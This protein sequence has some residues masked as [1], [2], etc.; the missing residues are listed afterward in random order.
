MKPT[1]K[2]TISSSDSKTGLQIDSFWDGFQS[3]ISWRML[4]LMMG[5]LT[6]M[7]SWCCSTMFFLWMVGCVCVMGSLS[8][9]MDENNLQGNHG[10]PDLCRCAAYCWNS[11]C[12][13][14]KHNKRKKHIICTVLTYPNNK[15]I[16]SQLYWRKFSP[17]V[18]LAKKT[19][20]YNH[21]TSIYSNSP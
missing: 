13:M 17:L 14:A 7:G 19:I 4:Y 1:N 16:C 15:F 5:T 6:H 18:W 10:S 20:S 11:D 3:E 8:W 2:Q 9:T 21:K 12:K